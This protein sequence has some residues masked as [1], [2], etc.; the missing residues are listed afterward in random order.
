MGI[1]SET[2]KVYPRGKAIKHYKEKGYNAKYNQELEVKVEDLSE[3][4]TALVETIC[5]YCGK[6]REPIKYVTYNSQTKNGTQKCCCLDC[7]SLK[8]SEVI[9]EKYGYLNAMQVPEIK[10]KTQ[11]TNLHPTKKSQA[12]V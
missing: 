6:L 11:E 3:C 12:G 8:R 10:K 7:A 4:S 9:M 2:V 1:I 5:D